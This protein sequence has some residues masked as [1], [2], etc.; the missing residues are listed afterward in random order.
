MN[1]FDAAFQAKNKAASDFRARLN[2]GGARVVGGGPRSRLPPVGIFNADGSPHPMNDFRAKA[3]QVAPPVVEPVV[4]PAAVSQPAAYG[5][6]PG[7]S[8]G[9]RVVT[10]PPPPP[11]PVAP[12]RIP[13][14]MAP[15]AP[16]APAAPV[17]Q[18]VP[19]NSGPQRPS[20]FSRAATT[21]VNAIHGGETVG[22]AA[23]RLGK[24]AVEAGKS[25]AN[26]LPGRGA[27]ALAKG[28]MRAAPWVAAASDAASLA[29]VATDPNKTK[30]DVGAELA[31]DA[32]RWAA[33]G[34]GAKAG[35]GVGALTGPFAPAAVP[36]LGLAGGA[37]GYFGAD[38]LMKAFGGERPSDTSNGVVNQMLAGTPLGRAA[39]P[40]GV[41][42]AAPVA[43]KGGAPVAQS[44]ALSSDMQRVKD[45]TFD[46]N[47][48][49]FVRR[50]NPEAELARQQ[51]NANGLGAAVDAAF[52]AQ[53]GK[54]SNGAK[55]FADDST[56]AL[57]NT[58]QT[59]QGTGIQ[60]NKQANGVT[61]FSGN[62]VGG[63]GGKL[64]RAADGS[65]TSDWSK[66]KEYADQI[67]R[68]AKDQD[69]LAELTRGAAMSGDKESVARLTA[70]DGRLQAIA[71]KAATE[72]D[73]RQA[74]KGGSAKAA[75]V[76]AAMENTGTDNALKVQDLELRRAAMAGAQEDRDLDRALRR[77]ALTEKVATANRTAMKD[78]RE[79]TQSRMTALDKQLE[80]YATVDGKLDGQRLSRLRGLAANLK[81]GEGQSPEEFNKDV[82][83][84]VSLAS[85][86]DDGQAW[87]DKLVSQAGLGGTDLR[88][89]KAN[90]NR[91]R[92][93][94]TTDQGDHISTSQYNKLTD[95]EKAFFK[96]K[97]LQGS[98]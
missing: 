92:G 5:A 84:L 11:Q 31:G 96:S 62:N 68:N 63:M 85:K 80:Q 14:T 16:A 52:H 1:N 49:P 43:T 54:F 91:W 23:S 12:T 8:L 20:G 93:G 9:S 98:E 47:N 76:L 35:A 87:Y 37:L 45:S 72:R 97:F 2:A 21:A 64:Y 53:R 78:A 59:L 4:G 94:F 6:Q 15:A 17:V 77:D 65:V 7:A 51:A 46:P 88:K 29:D 55:A 61:E 36:V 40:D 83:T 22:E 95:D 39:T 82:T 70:G 10:P 48:N 19:P 18:P 50:A 75:Q 41:T 73:L 90:P 60:A 67:Q 44:A 34:L 71:E 24:G 32:G 86:L 26:S 74:V 66:T 27:T 58:N 89:W 69:R 25:V 57:F 38:K 13:V 30:L 42:Q 3:A 56:R 79:V 81:P 33:A 28:S